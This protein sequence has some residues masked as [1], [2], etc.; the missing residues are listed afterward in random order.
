MLLPFPLNLPQ[1][2]LRAELEPTALRPLIE[3][4]PRGKILNKY[5]SDKHQIE[6]WD[7]ICQISAPSPS[8]PHLLPREFSQSIMQ[9]APG[10]CESPLHNQKSKW[11]LEFSGREGEDA[12]SRTMHTP[13]MGKPTRQHLN[14]HRKPTGKH[15][16][17]HHC[18]M[19]ARFHPGVAIPANMLLFL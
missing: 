9:T 12:T 18:K 14:H 7:Q 6:S 5:P 4:E 19:D 2:R 10:Q 17:N 15:S 16:N 13:L 1:S 3:S 11:F 8:T